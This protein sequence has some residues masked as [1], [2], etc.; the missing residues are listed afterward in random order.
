MSKYCVLLMFVLLGCGAELM[1]PDGGI[2]LDGDASVPV[3]AD[4]GIP[5]A[6][7]AAMLADSAVPA[8]D[9]GEVL[10]AGLRAGLPV[11]VGMRFIPVQNSCV[12]PMEALQHVD[13]SVSPGCASVLFRLVT[14]CDGMYV[15]WQRAADWLRTGT[16]YDSQYV[17]PFV[18]EGVYHR[19]AFSRDALTNEVRLMCE[20]DGFP[21]EV[22]L[23]RQDV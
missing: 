2:P 3:Y 10:C 21:C 12:G 14:I 6:D 20:E 4:A 7:A 1:P 18:C 19:C 13:L 15:P 8:M 11:D 23:E 22:V 5:D 16:V 9:S 17:E